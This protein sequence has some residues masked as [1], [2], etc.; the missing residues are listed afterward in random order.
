MKIIALAGTSSEAGKTTVGAFI[1]KSLG[2]VCALKVTVQHE[3]SC[4]RHRDTSC[5]GC[6]S[7]ADFSI[8]T[9]PKIISEP[10]KDT[11]RYLEAGAPKVVWLQTNSDC[12]QEGIRK[13]LELFDDGASVLVEGNRFVTV[14]NADLAI[15]VAPQ[16]LQKVKRSAVEIFDKIDLLVLNRWSGVPEELLESTRKRWES[17]GCKAPALAIDPYNPEPAARDALLNRIREAINPLVGVMP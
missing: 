3:G 7:D 16:D 17:M 13:S 6:S 1:I 9:D 11:A 14:G 8:L 12:A 15:M 2:N 5:D 4:P 10:G